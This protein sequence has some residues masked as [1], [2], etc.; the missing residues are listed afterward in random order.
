[1]NPA[2]NNKPSYIKNPVYNP[3]DVGSNLYVNANSTPAVLNPVDQKIEQYSGK[4]KLSSLFK[5]AATSAIFAT[6]PILNAAYQGYNLLNKAPAVK[7]P[8][9]TTPTTTAQQGTATP[10]TP[11]TVTSTGRNNTISA[12]VQTTPAANGAPAPSYDPTVTGKPV[13]TNKLSPDELKDLA[14]KAGQAGLSLS[15]YTELINQNSQLGSKES[16][17]IRT[18]LGIEEARAKALAKPN[19]SSAQIYERLY[20]EVGL[21]DI[22]TKIA[23][24]DE[25]LN[26]KRDDFTKVEGEIK[27]NPWLSSTSRRGRLATAASLALDDISND[28][29]ARQQYLDLYTQGVGEVESRLGFAVADQNLERELDVE[30]LNYLLNE[31]ERKSGLQVT[32]NVTAGLRNV[33]DFIAG[34]RGEQERLE[35]KADNIRAQERAD[36]AAKIGAGAVEVP[37]LRLDEAGNIVA[38][39]EAPKA[40][41]EGERQTLI[42]FQRMAD[43]IGN[44]DELEKPIA[45]T[46]LIGQLQMKAFDMPLFLTKNQQQYEQASRAFTEARLRKDSGAAIP[47]SEFASDRL[48]YFP[49]PGDSVETLAQKAQSRKVAINGLRVASGNAYWQLYGVNPVEE[50]IAR[51]QETGTGGTA[52]KAT[53]A[54]RGYVSTLNLNK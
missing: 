8:Q 14:T 41:T 29:T 44:L 28:L 9:V 30:N 32:D 40:P 37:V 33:P 43:A 20:K 23:E 1:M 6:N 38:G 39:S 3:S 11:N 16:E 36:A 46:G 49:Q 42:F 15:E 47:D 4:N 10:A 35:Q 34:A 19:E 45:D 2:L 5:T 21:T 7:A 51:L 25:T 53:E 31:A 50:T 17:A 52:T 12:P 54:D 13:D 18:E 22:K 48:T 27:N 26:K 24:I